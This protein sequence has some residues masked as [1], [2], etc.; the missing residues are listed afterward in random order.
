MSD[1]SQMT[2]LP[3][4]FS[5]QVRLFPLPNVVLFPGVIQPL[6]IFEPRYCDMLE[7][8]LQ[9]DRLIAMGL[10]VPGWEACYE[11]RPQVA[12]MVCVGKIISHSTKGDRRHNILLAGIS[13]ATISEELPPTKSFRSAMVELV[14]DDYDLK[15]APQRAELRRRIAAAFRDLVPA[16][17]T[18]NEQFEELLSDRISLGMLTD[19]VAYT[20]DLDL[21]LKQQLLSEPNVD[22]RAARL[23]DALT[24]LQQNE[25]GSDQ[26]FPPK[27]SDN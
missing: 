22:S 2:Q 5:G 3:D 9:G 6:H 23:L 14:N 11:G 12:P 10:L 27:F 8:A 16:S 24:A 20:I 4:D 19:V 26:P 1:F 15:T 7:D 25:S 21:Q 17:V 18:A 13:R